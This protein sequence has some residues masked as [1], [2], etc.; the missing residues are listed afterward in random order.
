MRALLGRTAL[1]L[2]T[3]IRRLRFS[4]GEIARRLLCWRLHWCLRFTV[5]RTVL[6]LHNSQVEGELS[7]LMSALI[8]Q[9]TNRQWTRLII[10][11][12]LGVTSPRRSPR[13]RPT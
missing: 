13:P 6:R 11:I 4:D 9:R 10:K 8:Q 3:R 2:G 12:K 7:T 5:T 1:T